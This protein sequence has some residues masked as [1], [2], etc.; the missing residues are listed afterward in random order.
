MPDA[1]VQASYLLPV[2]EFMWQDSTVRVDLLR[3]SRDHLDEFL[4]QDMWSLSNLTAQPW[5]DIKANKPLPQDAL[6]RN[7][8]I[9]RSLRDLL[10]AD[11]IKLDFLSL[12]AVN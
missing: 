5:C 8:L 7:V 2:K 4:A 11:N 3:I 6:T 12:Q 1:L 9:L 10:H